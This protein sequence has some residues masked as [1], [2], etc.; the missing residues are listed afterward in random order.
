M[1]VPLTLGI[2]L[3]LSGC[4]TPPSADVRPG[5]KPRVIESAIAVEWVADPATV[6]SVDRVARTVT[7][8]VPGSPLGT[9]KIGPRVRNW[10]NVHVGDRVHATIEEVLRVY[11]APASQSPPARVLLVDP[12]Y[13]VLTI[14]Y[15]NGRT[16]AFKIGLDT[17]MEGIEAGD[18]IAIRPV[19][20][21]GLQV[22]HHSGREDGS[23][24]RQSGTSA[25]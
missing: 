4:W 3:C 21:I 17:P 24:S 25:R 13:R 8:S 10:G 16:E 22:Q 12:S 20:V 9:Y 2:A 11:V 5:G 6:E 23:R 1:R 19:E 15:P 7:L 14:R 18:S